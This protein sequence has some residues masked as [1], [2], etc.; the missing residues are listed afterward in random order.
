[1]VTHPRPIYSEEKKNSK[2]ESA[3]L[4]KED[5]PKSSRELFFSEVP[6]L[7]LRPPELFVIAL[8]FRF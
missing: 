4:E 7:P 1:L 3:K 8:S 5:Q 6:K 2:G